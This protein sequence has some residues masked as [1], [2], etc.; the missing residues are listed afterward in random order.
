[1]HPCILTY[2]SPRRTP[3]REERCGVEPRLPVQHRGAHLHREPRRARASA[4][5]RAAGVVSWPAGGRRER[6]GARHPRSFPRHCPSGPRGREPQHDL[7]GALRGCAASSGGAAA[8][9]PEG[10][11]PQGPSRPKIALKCQP[12]SSQQRFKSDPPEVGEAKELLCFRLPHP[13]ARTWSFFSRL[14]SA[15]P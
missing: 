12:L 3:A 1:M 10:W 4:S 7:P 11:R 15:L 9:G 13:R 14:L 5:R 6:G 8:H 2:P